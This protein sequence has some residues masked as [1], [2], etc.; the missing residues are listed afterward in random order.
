MVRYVNI[1]T[2]PND[3][4]DLI[5]YQTLIRVGNGETM[6]STHKGT[7]TLPGTNVKLS[8]LL[9]PNAIRPLISVNKLVQA[10]FTVSLRESDGEIQAGDITIPLSFMNGFWILTKHEAH[11]T[12]R[13][14]NNLLHRRL[15]HLS[16]ANVKYLI[17]P[18]NRLL[19]DYKSL[20]AHSDCP[21]CVEANLPVKKSGSRD[22]FQ[23]NSSK[24]D[25]KH[26]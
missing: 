2:D 22:Y 23:A 17:N 16:M 14:N 20:T 7:I 13:A 3:M 18:K 4:Q 8:A 11:L 6:S 25:K 26:V 12:T 10:K 24:A 1:M 19:R 15:G 21:S 9:C 5:P